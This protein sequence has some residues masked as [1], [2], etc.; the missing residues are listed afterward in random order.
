M[1]K[2]MKIAYPSVDQYILAYPEE[3]QEILAKIRSVI[4]K[5]APDALESISYGMPAYKL[6][7]KP[8][9]YFGAFRTHIGF[10]ATPSGHME[11]AEEFS[12]YKHGKGS[13]Q[14][15]LNK[16]IPYK[17]IEQVVEFRVHE[18]CTRYK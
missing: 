18:V 8:L 17:L 12:K 7:G 5:K 14:F 16:P 6:R 15:P 2:K 13:V 9:V 1:D 11:F 10:F 3:I 4:R